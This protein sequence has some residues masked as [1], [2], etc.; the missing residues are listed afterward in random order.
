MLPGTAR[1]ETSAKEVIEQVMHAYG[2]AETV[3]KIRTVCAKGKIVAYAFNAAGT[4]S[5]CVAKDRK[6]RVDIDYG[7]FVERRVLNGQRA[8]VRQ[9]DGSTQ[10]LTGGMNYLSVVYQYEQLS[11]PGALLNHADRIRYDGH[12][13]HGDRQVEVLSMDFD[14]SLPI[15]IYVDAASGRIVKTSCAF[16]MGKTQMVLSSDFYDFKAVGKTIFPFRFV[17][18]AGGEKIAETSILEYEPNSS[19]AKDTF[20]IPETD[21]T[22]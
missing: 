21:S 19:P 4:Y 6:L 12:E 5:Y 3:G 7:S 2:G 9:G 17:N 11:L 14:G 16:R 8:F 15:K 10:I 13:R 22:P 20:L 18:Y 1:T